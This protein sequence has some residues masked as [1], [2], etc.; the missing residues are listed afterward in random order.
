MLSRGL[1]YPLRGCL[2]RRNIAPLAAAVRQQRLASTAALTGE[3]LEVLNE[4]R[5]A[6][7]YDVVIVGGGPAGLATAIRLRQ[8]SEETGTE[9]SVCMV[10]KGGT[11]GAHILSGNVFEPRALDE[12]LPGWEEMGA[13]TGVAAGSDSLKYLTEKYALPLP[14]P[15]TLQ[16]HGNRILSLGHLCAWMGEKAEELG[17]EIYP[18]FAASEVI[19]T[20]DGAVKGIATSD[21]GIG[22]DSAPN[23]LFARGMELHGRQV[24]FAEGCRGSCSQEILEKFQL[25]EAKGADPQV[26]GLGIKEVW[27]ID[28]ALHKEGT[29]VHTIGWPLKTD[30]YGGSFLYHAADHQVFM[31]FVVGLDYPNP[32]LSPYQEFQRWKQHPE[33]KPLLEG[34]EC[35]SYGARCINEGGW[36]AVP[37]LTFP[38]GALVGCSAGFVNVP[39][40]KGSHT[41]MKSGMLA[42]E[43]MFE[44]LTSEANGPSVYDVYETGEGEAVF[45]TEVPK[46]EEMLEASWV[47]EELWAVRNVHP[48]FHKIGPLPAQWAGMIYSGLE[49]FVLKGRGWWTLKAGGLDSAATKPAAE[50]QEIEYPK[51]DG[52]VSFDLLTNLS[53]SGVYHEEDQP[54]HLRIKPELAHIPESISMQTY[55]APET[56]FCPAKVY[57]YTEPEDGSAPQLVINAQNCVHCKC[58]SI[59]MPGEYIKWTVPQG[60]G[61]P[62]YE[63][64]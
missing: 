9:L 29:I 4:P 62:M 3:Q 26:Y 39:K 54:A 28:P 16:N 60:G 40:I 59:K 12:L 24:V 18:G 56:R 20:E 1:G 15:P 47:K 25:R 49:T 27:K 55:A 64:M 2:R 42:A 13:P 57:E 33:I 21:V 11:V 35:L 30:T 48:S 53:R 31:G 5:E 37:K 10:E 50:C 23:D 6:M 51:P 43:A 19:Y 32:Y 61:G 8:L 58:C 52:V 14:T 34:G 45:G 41:A 7:E 17:V 22:R 38:G 46:Y 36:Q 63:G 44:A